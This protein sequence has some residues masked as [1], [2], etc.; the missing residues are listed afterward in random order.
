MGFVGFGCMMLIIHVFMFAFLFQVL[1]FVCVVLC[2]SY[3]WQNVLETPSCVFEEF[4]EY[5]DC[6]MHLWLC[7]L[8]Y[9]LGCTW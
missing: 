2:I 3:P 7:V 8:K 5:N 6:K 9:A 1:Y 4:M